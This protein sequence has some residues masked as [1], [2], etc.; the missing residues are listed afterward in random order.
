MWT[1]GRIRRRGDAPRPGIL[2][3]AATALRR[4]IGVPVSAEVAAELR[5]ERDRLAGR[6]GHLATERALRR[7]TELELD[8]LLRRSKRPAARS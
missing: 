1:V 7:R 8:E 2:N 3:C 6:L 5:Q 4:E